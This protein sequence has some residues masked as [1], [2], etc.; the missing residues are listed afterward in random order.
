[1]AANV[2]ATPGRLYLTPTAVT[3][4]SG[5]LISGIEERALLFDP[6]D[7]DVRLRRTGTAEADGF[8]IRRGRVQPARLMLP[9]RQQDTTGLTLLLSHLTTD[10]ALIR[11]TGG[12]AAAQF[13]ALPVFAMVLRPFS[14][15]EKYLYA[16]YWSLAPGSVHLIQ[17]AELGEQL[18]GA[19]LEFI[20]MRPTNA[21]AGSPPYLWGTAAAIAAAFG[22]S[23]NPA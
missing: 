21:T 23:E 14:T 13:A 20:P 16:P 1:M 11:P 10:G 12:T 9:L 5:T 22:I 8:R 7:A 4:T 15:S 18:E 2:Y 19:M 3:G 6:G 17:H